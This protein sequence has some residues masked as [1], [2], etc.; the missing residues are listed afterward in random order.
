MEDTI[1]A[2]SK[3]RDGIWTGGAEVMAGVLKCNV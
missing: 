1:R 2:A 3:L